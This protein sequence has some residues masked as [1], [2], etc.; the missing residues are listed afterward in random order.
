VVTPGLTWGDDVE[1]FAGQAA[2]DAHHLDFLRGF[3]IHAHGA[4]YR[5]SGCNLNER[6]PTGDPGMHGSGK[7]RK[8]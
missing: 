3:Q 1:H 2:G 8:A 7:E 6:H 4:H 5:R